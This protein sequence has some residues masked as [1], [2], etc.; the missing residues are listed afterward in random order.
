MSVSQFTVFSVADDDPSRRYTVHLLAES[1]EDAEK[2][3]V[4]EAPF[5][6]T[7]AAVAKGHVKPLDHEKPDLTPILSKGY[8]TQVASV[9]VSYKK[10][11][12][13]FTCP[14]CKA[15]LHKYESVKQWDYWD[16]YWEGRI[17]RGVYTGDHG[18]AVNHEK[19]TRSGSGLDTTIVAVVIQCLACEYELWNGYKEA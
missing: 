9:R 13:P 3:A 15:G 10:V 14:K 4:L 12:L 18:I 2:K 16:Y 11:R 6:I 8:E 17:P 1:P 5:A 7:V 19:G